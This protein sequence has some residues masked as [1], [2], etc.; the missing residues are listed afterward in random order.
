MTRSAARDRPASVGVIG[1]GI[2]GVSAALEARALGLDVTLY[3][4]R[5]D[6][7]TGST[8]RNFFRLHR[9]Y[10]YPRDAPTAR[11]AR[12]G[13]ET[14]AQTFADA[15]VRTAPHHYAIAATGSRTSAEEFLRHCADLGLRARPVRLPMLV[16]GSVTACFEVEESYYDPTRLRRLCWNR[17]RQSAVRVQLACRT[18]ARTVRRAHDVL[19]V[20]AYSGLNAVLAALGC[21]TM[22]LRYD[23]CEVAIVS[24]PQ[25]ARCSVVVLDGP[26]LSVAP[27]GVDLHLLYDVVHSVRR[28]E[29]GRT[30]PHLG[31]DEQR[32][33]GPIELPPPSAGFPAIAASARRFVRPLTGL[34]HVGSLYSERVVLPDVAATDARPSVA[35]RLTPGVIAVLSG[36]VSSSVDTARLVAGMIAAELQ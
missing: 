21:P 3:E 4:R 23:V 13:Y 24:A 7:L 18:D 25:L 17:L 29:T 9:G 22:E 11:Q 31:E 6:I 28:R 14:F 1:A 15:V 33:A 5:S 26:F 35:R 30:R 16:A 27:Y 36:K 32:I 10:H 20:T 19:V 8:A 34:Q 2:F 12:D